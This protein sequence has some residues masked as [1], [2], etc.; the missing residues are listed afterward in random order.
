M[1]KIYYV[2]RTTRYK[3]QTGNPVKTLL[4][5]GIVFGIL[6]STIVYLFQ[7]YTPQDKVVLAAE[8]QSTITP[9]PTQTI[10]PTISNTKL[11]ESVQYELEGTK[12]TYS[13]YIKNLKTN[14]LYAYNEHTKYQSASLYKLWVMAKV[15][16]MIKED[17]LKAENILSEDVK[18]LNSKFKIGSE[19]A[20]LSEGT[21]SLPIAEALTRMITYSDNYSAMI[22]TQKIKLSSVQP[23]LN[24]NGFL[25]TKMG[26]STPLPL[27]TAF[28]IGLFFEKVYKGEMIDSEYSKKMLE[29]LKQQKI[30]RKLPLYLPDDVVIAHKTGELDAYTHDAGIVYTPKG[31]YI[32]VV[33][34]KSDN[35]AAAEKRIGDISKAVYE[36]FSSNL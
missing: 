32:I 10:I 3:R 1:Q 36:Y 34:S 29:L 12:G 33:M 25:E 9:E 16:D 31:D 22:L 24:K 19:S 26:S 4:L 27:T 11:E 6:S 18:T 15:Y 35:P 17:K 28:D 7:S 14:E 20:E 30:N 21:I 2:K 13:I 5:F 23:F 8:S